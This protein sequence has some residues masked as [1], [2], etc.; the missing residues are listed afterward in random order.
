MHGW[1]LEMIYLTSSM[2]F[3]LMMAN[4]QTWMVEAL[5]WRSMMSI[6]AAVLLADLQK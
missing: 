1:F 3:T 5:A 2:N 4:F 6:A